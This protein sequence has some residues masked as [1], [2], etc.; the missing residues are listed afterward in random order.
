MNNTFSL[1]TVRK[2]RIKQCTEAGAWYAHKVGQLVEY[3]GEWPEG[4]V[5]H[6]DDGHKRRVLFKDAAIE[7]VEAAPFIPAAQSKVES[8]IESIANVVIGFVLSLAVTAYVLPAY[9][10]AITM[11]DNVQ[12]TLIFTLFSIAR[13]YALRRLFNSLQ[14]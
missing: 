7:H 14:G 1:T 6:D 4:Y 13:S 2:I 12:I 11:S 10:H 5:T 3:A 9:G 8:L